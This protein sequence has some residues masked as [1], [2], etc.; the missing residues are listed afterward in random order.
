MS[1]KSDLGF[2]YRFKD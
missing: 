2:V 1:T